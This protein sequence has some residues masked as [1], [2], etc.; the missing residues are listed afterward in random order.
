MNKSSVRFEFEK[1]PLHTIVYGASKTSWTYF[2]KHYFNLYREDENELKKQLFIVCKDERE[3]I[4]SATGKPYDG[5]IMC[6]ID[7]ITSESIDHFDNCL[8]VIDDMRSQLKIDMAEYFAGGRH[9]D[10]QMIVI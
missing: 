2:V 1:S 9:D 7:M 10:I 6:G 3:W 4:N 8:I 5:F